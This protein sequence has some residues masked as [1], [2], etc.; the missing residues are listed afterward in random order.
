MEEEEDES[1]KEEMSFYDRAAAYVES[2]SK[3]NDEFPGL[4]DVVPDGGY[5]GDLDDCKERI[6]LLGKKLQII[7]KLANIHLVYL[8]IHYL[9]YV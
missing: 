9:I 7:V 8:F 1:K 6:S 5:P 4:P 2:M 3:R